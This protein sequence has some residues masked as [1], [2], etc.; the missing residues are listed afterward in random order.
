MRG[1]TGGRSAYENRPVASTKPAI[2]LRSLA[3]SARVFCRRVK[4]FAE[5]LPGRAFKQEMR[6]RLVHRAA[7]LTG[8]EE[9]KPDLK[10]EALRWEGPVR[11]WEMIEMFYGEW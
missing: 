7:G 1:E 9:M 10:R 11:S 4:G 8:W 3:F 2:A 6:S 5:R